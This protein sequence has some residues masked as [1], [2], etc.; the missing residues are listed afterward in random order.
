MLNKVMLLVYFM[1]HIITRLLM[2]YE[3]SCCKKDTELSITHCASPLPAVRTCL[4]VIVMIAKIPI[5][6]QWANYN[7]LSTKWHRGVISNTRFWY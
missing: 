5:Y 1:H 2:D 6:I 7:I 3:T 4:A